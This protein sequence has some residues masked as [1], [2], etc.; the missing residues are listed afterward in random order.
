MLT[1]TVALLLSAVA[2]LFGKVMTLENQLAQLT[3]AQQQQAG[4]R[5]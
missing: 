3:A 1:A 4:W 5:R 2:L